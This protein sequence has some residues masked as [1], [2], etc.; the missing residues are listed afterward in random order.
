MSKLFRALFMGWFF[1]LIALVPAISFSQLKSSDKLPV[2]PKVKIGKLENGLTYY[3]RQNKKPE[4]KV[5][6]RLVV[7]AGS[8]NEDDDQQG[9]AHMAEHMAFNGTANFKKNDIISYLQSIGVGFGNDLNAY[10]SFDET[11]YILPIPTDKPGNLEKGFQILEDW[12][13]QISF[14]NEDIDQERAVILEESRL[15]KGASDR[16]YRKLYPK[17]FSG[18]LYANRIP[19]GVDSII[20]SYKHDVIRRFY[21]D[22]YRPNL[23]AVMVVG[24]IEPSKAEAMIRKHFAK[25]TNPANPRPR[26][27]TKIPAYGKTEAMV[28]TDKEATN[29]SIE[30][31]HSS[32]FKVPEGTYGEYRSDIVKSLYSSI[33]NLR[34]RELTQK[35]NPPFLFANAGFS[36]F[37][38]DH[39]FFGAEINVGNSDVSKALAAYVEELERV[40]RHGFT[41]SELD[42]AKSNYMNNI[43]RA[44]NEREKTESETYISEYVRNFLEKEVIPGIENEYKYSKEILPQITLGE[45]NALNDLL[46]NNPNKFIALTGPEPTDKAKLPSGEDLLAVVATVEKADVKAYEEKAVA[47]SLMKTAPASGKV[48]SSTKN[49]KLGTTELKLANGVTVTLKPTDFKNDQILMSAIRPGGKNNYSLADKFNADYATQ[50]V[51]AMGIGEFSPTDLRKVLAGKTASVSPVFGATTDGVSGSSSVKDLETMFQLLHL[52]F[53]APRKDTSLFKSFLQKNKSQ[54]AMVAANPQAAFID[55]FFKTMYANNPL[56]T[57][58][59]GRSENFDKI[60]LDR[61]LAI[62]K[63]RFGDANGMHFTFVGSF[64]EDQIRPLIEKYVASL[65]ATK[66]VFKFA[67]NKLRPAKG[68]INL[69]FNRGKEEKSLVLAFYSGELPYSEEMELRA[70]ALSE[71]LNIRI[72]EELREK[73]QGIY[74]GGINAQFDKY[75]YP[76]YSFVLQLPSGPEKV[77]TLLYAV[78]QEI[79]KLKTQGPSQADLDKV[80]Q[81]WREQMKEARKENSA[82]LKALQDAKF[83]GDD[84]KYFLEVE[85]YIDALTV[86]DVKKAANMLLTGENVVTGVL[87]PESANASSSTSSAGSTSTV[88]NRPGEVMTTI[89][90]TSPEFK[91]ELYDNADIDGDIVTL[92][93]NGQVVSSKQKLT[94]KAITL[95]LKANPNRNNELVMFAENLGTI[96]PNT[97][98]M[99]VYAAGKTYEVRVSADE[100]KN[101]V[102]VFKMK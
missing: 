83:P 91:V 72:I 52:Y 13:H 64:K 61:A 17:L 25:L 100:K 44:Y 16:M 98:L 33:L 22:W 54:F 102:V 60:N 48:V 14:T 79:N 81:Q 12:A 10:T 28:V 40:K 20:R 53:T 93:F 46:K 34:L 78:N 42:R 4:Q 5:E 65:P 58:P 85:K 36:G 55:T 90:L 8:I 29:Y 23:M 89:E 101:G 99:K 95:N 2:D 37:V 9:L 51:Q 39:E 97:A 68:K 30:I 63:E 56:A 41:Q 76:R 80:K 15:G 21:K 67:D 84:I 47:S 43:E 77:D 92:Y 7:N 18:S 26:V 69:N 27:S 11:V 45:V 49:A 87:R 31:Y 73:I 59:I 71:I 57:S 88:G 1:I 35:E 24:D 70:N 19:I 62:Y 94:D 3:I 96:P 38:R 82:W 6:L 75:P 66:K 86:A 50:I 32:E 74:T